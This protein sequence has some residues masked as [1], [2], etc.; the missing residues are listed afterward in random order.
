M[1]DIKLRGQHTLTLI[2]DNN[3]SNIQKVEKVNLF[4][5]LNMEMKK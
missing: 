5:T 1:P 2:S 3:K 4:D